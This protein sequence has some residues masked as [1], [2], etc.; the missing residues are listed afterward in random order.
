MRRK[1]QPELWQPIRVILIQDDPDDPRQ[2]RHVLD[3][4]PD[5]HVVAAVDDWPDFEKAD[6]HQAHVLVV[7]YSCAFAAA[8]LL[9]SM[10]RDDSK[11]RAVV[12]LPSNEHVFAL[13]IF[14][15]GA[16]A[17]LANDSGYDQVLHA[18]RS[19]SFGYTMIG[20]DTAEQ[21]LAKLHAMV[22]AKEQL[23]DSICNDKPYAPLVEQ[24]PRWRTK[25]DAVN[26]STSKDAATILKT[27][28]MNGISSTTLS[29]REREVLALIVKG[30]SNQQIA[31][32]LIISLPTAKAHV[33]NILTKLSV[34]DR[35][36]AAVT[37]MRMGL[38]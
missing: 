5:L 8:N 30:L 20:A 26:N 12:L 28:A 7:D 21:M 24:I 36:Q 10:G 2:I 38:V 34:S 29:P 15:A 33:R 17:C 16:S 18:I 22:S 27:P 13:P 23:P 25:K 3:L 31:D 11:I 1:N 9:R 32:H 37:A 19:A 6:E 4:A 14:M 35:T